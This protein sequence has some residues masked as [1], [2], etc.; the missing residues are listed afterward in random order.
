MARYIDADRE[1][2]GFKNAILKAEHTETTKQILV[3]IVEYLE[4]APTADVVEVVR[5]KD[6]KNWSHASR[7][8]EHMACDMLCDYYGRKYPTNPTDFCSYG[9]RRTDNAG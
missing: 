8:T 2:Q 3:A 6:C 4:K 5:C 7:V 9:E 1:I